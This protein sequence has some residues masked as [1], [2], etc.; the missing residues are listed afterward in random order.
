VPEFH[1]RRQLGLVRRAPVFRRLFLSTLVSGVGTWIAVIALT[2]DVYDRTHSAKWVSALLIADFLP[3]V[4]IGLLGGPLV[5]RLPRKLLLVGADLVRF[6]VFCALPF[7]ASAGHIVVLAFVAG[8]AT[9]FQRPALLAGLP[10]L[11]EPDDLPGANGLLR[12]IEYMTTTT[13]TLLGGVIAGSAGPHTAYWLNAASFALSAVLVAGIPGRLLQT[14]RAVSR[15]HFRDIGDGFRLVLH[16]R[17]L[18][19]VFFAWNLVMLSNGLVNV[20]EIALAKVSFNSGSFGFGLMWTA[21]GVGMVIG[22]LVAAGWLAARGLAL[23]YGGALALMGFGTAAA[24]GSPNVWVAI[25]ALAIAGAGNGAA[26]VY[27]SLLVQRGAPDNLR[28]RV[29]TTI[30]SANFALLGLS[31]I[32]AGPLTDAIGARWVYGIAAALY[33]AAAVVG[34]GLS[35]KSVEEPQAELIAA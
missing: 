21:S 27:N 8:V 4:L 13:G 23:V 14:A 2:V 22:T 24:A 5:D 18:L 16:S 25:V 28:G 9:G 30:M 6:A 34:F 17:A 26:V 31:M 29:F 12:T 15:G 10:N 1:V 20:S 33:I 3:A 19:V 32:A 35:R 7:A 11:V